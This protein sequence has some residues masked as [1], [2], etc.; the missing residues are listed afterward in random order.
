[1]MSDLIVQRFGL[2]SAVGLAFSQFSC[3][4]IQ[5]GLLSP[6]KPLRAFKLGSTTEPPISSRV[7]IAFMLDIHE[8][9]SCSCS[10]WVSSPFPLFSPLTSSLKRLTN[11]KSTSKHVKSEPR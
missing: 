7:D 10:G 6:T 2:K 3:F 9:E 1:M 11:V 4:H 8:Q 5:C